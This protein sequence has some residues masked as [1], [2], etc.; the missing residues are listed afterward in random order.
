MI[1]TAS[2]L[3]T[4]LRVIHEAIR[5]TVA[6]SGEQQTTEQLAEVVA[7][8]AGDTIFA[9]D[10]ISEEVLIEHFTVLGQE[11]SFVLIAEGLG[12]TGQM[13]FPAG[14]D[15]AQAELRI[16]M[17]PID[18]TRGI[19]YQKRSAWI[20]TGVAPNHG[21]Q[22]SLSDIEIAVQTEIPLV[23]QHLCDSLW[24]IKGEGIGGERFN[25]QTRERQPL[26]PQPSRA[27]TIAYGYG[28]VSRFFPGGRAELADIDDEIIYRIMGNGTPGQAS[29]YEDQYISTGGQLYELLM[30][31]DRWIA[32]LRP[33]LAP[34]LHTQGHPTSLCC[35][36]YDLCTELIARE[37]GLIITDAYEQPLNA[38]LDVESDVTWIGYANARIH[39]QVAPVL[40]SILSEKKLLAPALHKSIRTLED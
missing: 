4:Q 13:T 6:K 34:L 16:I 20:L 10:R 9:I 31:H 7:Q 33:L 35:H 36:P 15:P 22:T 8:Q 39:Q 18:G 19:M 29:V 27:T 24:A 40:Q 37:A 26:I 14:T 2:R 38:P 28:S 21:E 1:Q 5:D 32:D 11:R 12:E 17:D 30:G 25:R 23:K 3:L